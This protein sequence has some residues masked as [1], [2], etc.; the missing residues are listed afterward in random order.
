MSDNIRRKQ[1]LTGKQKLV[2][3]VIVCVYFFAP[4]FNAISS[5]LALMPDYYGISPSAA[6]WITVLA[7]PLACVAGL[8]VG[9]L[10]GKKISYRMCAILATVLFVIFGGLPF[11]WRDIPFAALLASRAMFGL[12]CGCFAPL[13]Q[14]VI[15]HMFKDESARAAWI[16]IVNIIFSIGASAG[17]MVTGALAM[18]GVWQNA[19]A[20]Y[21][22]CIIPLVLVVLFFRDKEFIS[23]EELA[24]TVDENKPKEKRTIPGI[25]I[26]FIVLFGFSVLLTQTFYGYGGIAMA[27]SGCDT[28]LTGTVFT[29]FTVA[30]MVIATAN[31]PL[32]KTFRLYNLPI[33]FLLITLGYVLSLVGYGAGNVVFF[34]A[35][36]IVMGVGCCMGGMV[37]PMVM[38]VTCSA[39]ALT[40][41]IGLQEVA[42]NL[43]GFLSAP[44]LSTIGIAFGDTATV[45]FTAVLVLG[46]I[47]TVVSFIVTV[48]NTRKFK[49][50]EAGEK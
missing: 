10:V 31:A 49:S 35:A 33:A 50:M 7:S 3:V 18:D 21:L 20:F 11:L 39:G 23:E 37:M 13:A 26:T 38:S 27:E 32:W 6:S 9:T 41:A 24:K 4:T 42:R 47:C 44:W 25:A 36:A 1:K 30:S 17:T 40:L 12:G 45:Q 43:G 15:T 28:L 19:Y 46:I 48:K 2:L 22:F 29:V 8:G 16:G 34:F 5:T 14:S